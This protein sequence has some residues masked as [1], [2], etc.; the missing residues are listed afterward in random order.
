M[1]T[2]FDGMHY[3]ED[4]TEVPDGYFVWN[5]GRH[6]FPYERC[7]PLARNGKSKYLV[8]TR[9]LKYIEVP[10]EEIALTII[11]EAKRKNVGKRR[12]YEILNRLWK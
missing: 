6:N 10:T 9:F 3:F 12:F 1:R 5:I 8:D 4:V 11:R 2:I 7:V